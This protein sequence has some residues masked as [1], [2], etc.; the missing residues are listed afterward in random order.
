MLTANVLRSGFDGTFFV[1]LRPDCGPDSISTNQNVGFL[2]RAVR[3]VDGDAL[4][5]ILL[6]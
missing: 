4:V 6:S 3:Q 2:C 1:H 5:V